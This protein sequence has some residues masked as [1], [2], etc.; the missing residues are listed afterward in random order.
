MGFEVGQRIIGLYL[1]ELLIKYALDSSNITYANTH[2]LRKL[3]L[4]LPAKKRKQVE[5]KYTIIIQNTFSW[6]WSF[7]RTP[8][9]FLRHLGANPIKETRYF[10]NTNFQFRS[11]ILSPHNLYPLVYSLLIELHDYP[12]RSESIV[13]RYDTKFV[14]FEKSISKEKKTKPTKKPVHVLSVHWLE[15]FLDYFNA[16]FPHGDGEDPRRIGFSVGRQIIGLHLVELLMKYTLDDSG[17]RYQTDHNLISLYK[18][19]AN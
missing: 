3:Y 5:D 17:V 14:N 4:K 9:A 1:S 19:N 15:G 12:Q 7:A 13:K 18:K 8:N 6:T 11:Q 2:N 10:W 16:T